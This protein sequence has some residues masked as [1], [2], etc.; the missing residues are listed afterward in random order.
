MLT[1]PN[2]TVSSTTK[3]PTTTHPPI[4]TRPATT[5]H[6]T[7]E[8]SSHYTIVPSSMD[9]SE[10]YETTKA[11]ETSKTYTTTIP[12][13]DLS[14]YDL[15]DN[16]AEMVASD[17]VISPENMSEICNIIA[18]LKEDISKNSI[19][20]AE[21]NEKLDRILELF[22]DCE[23]W[24]KTL[25]RRIE[26]VELGQLTTVPEFFPTETTTSFVTY[27]ETT[28]PYT[29]KPHTT[30]PATQITTVAPTIPEVSKP[31][32]IVTIGPGQTVV[33]DGNLTTTEAS[34]TKPSSVIPS[35]GVV[36]SI[37]TSIIEFFHNLFI[38]FIEFL[39]SLTESFSDILEFF[40]SFFG[41][42][43]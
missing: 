5:E 17:T 22:P 28:L 43:K 24:V 42:M 37:F 16:I 26:E 30:V 39:I 21:I 36:A 9:P 7:P 29:T 12:Y 4:T 3:R 38:K 20:K 13:Q 33:D 35:T 25:K 40:T 23:I 1:F 41:N 31:D 10:S 27:P 8:S 2:L 32:V 18:N 19:S 15:L 6:I 14:V 34:V 11:N